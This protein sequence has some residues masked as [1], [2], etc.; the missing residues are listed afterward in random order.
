MTAVSVAS[1][2]PDLLTRAGA[3]LTSRNRADCPRCQGKRTLSYTSEVFYCHHVGC[4]FKGNAITLTR[5]LGLHVRHS[6]AEAAAFRQ[7]REEA[8]RQAAIAYRRV[9]HRRHELYEAHRE[10]IGTLYGAH[11]RLRSNPQDEIAWSALQLVYDQLPLVRAELLLLE[12]A[13]IGERLA[14]LQASQMERGEYLRPVIERSGLLAHDDR[15]VELGDAAHCSAMTAVASG[16]QRL[17]LPAP[18]SGIR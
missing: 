12:D 2:L 18:L 14:F 8:K 13:P 10:L 3:R 5:T 9:Q 11:S 1:D 16:L 17:I 15:F 4:D 6:P 7:R